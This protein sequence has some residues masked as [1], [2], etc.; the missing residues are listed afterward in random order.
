[1]LHRRL[2]WCG[3]AL[4]AGAEIV[5]T[6]LVQDTIT[7]ATTGPAADGDAPANLAASFRDVSPEPVR[8]KRGNE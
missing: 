8:A 1:M 2:E 6:R 7:R 3:V 4:S 5:P